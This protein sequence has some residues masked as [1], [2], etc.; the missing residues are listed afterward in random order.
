[1]YLCVNLI[2]AGAFA[3]DKHKAKRNSWRT[4]ENLLLLLAF[5]GPFGACGAM[6]LF[7]HKTRTIKFWLVPV[8]LVLHLAVIGYLVITC[9][10]GS[11]LALQTLPF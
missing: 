5:L 10:Y 1:M 7:R 2:A 3:W 11:G 8:F 6:R 4:S 9:R